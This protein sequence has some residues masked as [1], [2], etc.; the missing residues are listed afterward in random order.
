MLQYLNLGDNNTAKMP[1]IS[2]TGIDTKKSDY[3]LEII[4]K[5]QSQSVSGLFLERH[6][7]C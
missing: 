5:S 3:E 7:L 6:L 4:H 2:R 1:E